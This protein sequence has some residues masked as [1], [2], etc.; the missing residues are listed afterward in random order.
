MSVTAAVLLA[1]IVAA[2]ASPL[3]NDTTTKQ[4]EST[5]SGATSGDDVGRRPCR[6]TTTNPFVHNQVHHLLTVERATLVNYILNFSNYSRNPLTINTAGVYNAKKWSRATTAHGQ[7]LLSLA[8]NYGVLSMMTLTLG[9]ETLYVE[10]QDS[11]A[12]C[13]GALNDTEKVSSYLPSQSFQQATVER[14]YQKTLTRG[15]TDQFGNIFLL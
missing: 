9:T 6:L 12:A 15:R 3:A 14:Y 5:S 13:F 10:L 11:P 8:F 1:A 2:T 7:T 4:Q